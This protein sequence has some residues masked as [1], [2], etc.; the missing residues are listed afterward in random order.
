MEVKSTI[1]FDAQTEVVDSSPTSC[2]LAWAAETKQRSIQD[3]VKSL[4]Y[5]CHT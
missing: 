1:P 3:N 2:A 5:V 4:P